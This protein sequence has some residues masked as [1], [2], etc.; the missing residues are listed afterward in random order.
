M[1]FVVAVES[2]RRLLV[3]PFDTLRG[4]DFGFKNKNDLIF[5]RTLRNLQNSDYSVSR[6]GVGAILYGCPINKNEGWWGC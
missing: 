6:F 2:L 5:L 1:R 4:I 3:N